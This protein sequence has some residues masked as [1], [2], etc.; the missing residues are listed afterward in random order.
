MSD[1]AVPGD[2]GHG[3]GLALILGTFRGPAGTAT[4]TKSSAVPSDLA[5]SHFGSRSGI[6]ERGNGVAGWQKSVA[7]LLREAA[8][9]PSST[10]VLNDPSLLSNSRV[11]RTRRINTA[12]PLPEALVIGAVPAVVAS[13]AGVGEPGRVV[14]ELTQHPAGEHHAH[15]E[16]AAQNRRVGIPVRCHSQPGRAQR[17]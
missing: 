7:F 5:H 15:P 2:G 8:S 12:R 1:R 3:S 17:R 10:F 16:Q 4:S 6:A 9:S 14:P 11:L 13:A